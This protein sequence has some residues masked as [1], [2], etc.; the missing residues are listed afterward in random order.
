MPTVTGTIIQA[1]TTALALAEVAVAPA[2]HPAWLSDDR[3]VSSR[4]V[5]TLTGS[6]GTYSITLA[7]GWYRVTFDARDAFDISVPDVAGPLVM[8]D[9]VVTGGI[10]TLSATLRWFSDIQDMVT[11]DARTWIEGRTR[12]SYGSDGVI[13]GWDRILLTD[14]IAAGIAAN[15][16]SRL[17]TQDGLALCVRKFIA[18]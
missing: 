3:M 11:A 12:N 1:D 5:R 17:L 4:V 7:P 13:S 6:D 18:S 14:P 10:P 8:A 16:D 15:S 2:R 9:L